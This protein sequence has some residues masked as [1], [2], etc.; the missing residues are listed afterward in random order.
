MCVQDKLETNK[1]RDLL[2]EEVNKHMCT[3]YCPCWS[4]NPNKFLEPATGVVES[5]S[6]LNATYRNFAMFTGYMGAHEGE[7]HKFGRTRLPVETKC[8]SSGKMM[9]P[10]VWSDYK[11]KNDN[12]T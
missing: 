2:A 10:F 7:L 6:P 8:P 1:I 5:K 3:S 11:F 4:G 9:Q 12:K